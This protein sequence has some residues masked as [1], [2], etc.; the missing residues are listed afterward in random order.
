MALGAVLSKRNTLAGSNPGLGF[1]WL[2]WGFPALPRSV[3]ESR[4]SAGVNPHLKER[5][6]SAD[7]KPHFTTRPLFP[8]N[9]GSAINRDGAGRDS[10]GGVGTVTGE[11]AAGAMDELHGTEERLLETGDSDWEVLAPHDYGAGATHL[12]L[13]IAPTAGEPSLLDFPE[14]FAFFYE[15]RHEQ[16]EGMNED[17][18]EELRLEKDAGSGDPLV[19][20]FS[21]PDS[22]SIPG[23]RGVPTAGHI[24]ATSG[25]HARSPAPASMQHASRVP[26]AARTEANEIDRSLHPFRPFTLEGEETYAPD[27]TEGI[28]AQALTAVG[29]TGVRGGGVGALGAASDVSADGSCMGGW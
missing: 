29:G 8:R 21:L 23:S 7:F 14:S 13:D 5:Q 26:A 9:L 3:K 22:A 27:E 17:F 12:V 25:L 18:E 24:G 1:R 4:G 11:G 20:P 19:Q 6:G 2:P 10:G 28:V 16:A 15:R